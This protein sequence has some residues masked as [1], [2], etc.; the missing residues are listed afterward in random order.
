MSAKSQVRNHFRKEILNFTKGQDLKGNW[1][2]NKPVQYNGVDYENKEG[3]KVEDCCGFWRMGWTIRP[4]EGGYLMMHWTVV[5]RTV[6]WNAEI[7]FNKKMTPMCGYVNLF[8]GSPKFYSDGES[9]SREYLLPLIKEDS[10]SINS[11][12]G[13]VFK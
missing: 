8:M 5:N 3:V 7:R 9:I 12:K 13:F 6:S 2:I 10:A 11:E 1:V 4:C